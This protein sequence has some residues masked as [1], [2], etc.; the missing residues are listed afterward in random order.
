MTERRLR[1]AHVIIQPVLVWDDGEELAPGPPVQPQTVPLTEVSA[2]NLRKAVADLAAQLAA[3]KG[4]P[5]ADAEAAAT[6][7]VGEVA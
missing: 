4:S 6:K 2:E 3:P 5:E 1:V 7:A